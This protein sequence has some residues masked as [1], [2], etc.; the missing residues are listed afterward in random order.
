MMN[1]T[2]TVTLT[3]VLAATALMMT[4]CSTGAGSSTPDARGTTDTSAASAEGSAQAGES[5]QEVAA[6]TPRIFVTYDGGVLALD[7]NTGE[8]QGAVETP[9]FLRLNHAGDGRH[10]MVTGG[11]QFRVLDSGLIT[12]EHGDHDHYYQQDPA[13]TGAAFEASEAGHVVSHHGRTALFADGTGQVQ[14]VE[15]SAFGENAESVANDAES[16][17]YLTEYTTQDSHHGVAIPISDGGLLVTQGTEQSRHT[18]QALDAQG[19]VT[20]QTTDCPGVHGEAVVTGADHGGQ[21]GDVVSFG[22]ENGPVVFRDGQFHKVAVPQSYQRSGNQFAAPGSPVVLTDYKVDADA[23]LERPTRVG[24]LD[25]R[26]D[27]MTTVDLGSPYWFRSLARGAEGQGVVLT[28]DGQ[29]NIIDPQTGEIT[30]RVEVT[31]PWEEN[32]NWQQPGPAVQ[33]SGAY[34]YVT[35]PARQKLHVVNVQ[36]GTVVDTFDL[37][38]T[39]N[40]LAVV[41]GV[42]KSD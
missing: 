23:E 14:V 8:V 29:L 4:A 12:R 20:A 33:V 1:R 28:Y 9:G 10:L 24:L 37:P 39:P 27:Q 34:A 35:E 41:N 36:T 17:N 31:E 42:K 26:S 11:D 5:R 13:W 40:E 19:N 32:E 15:T 7:G 3:S 2:R 6:L 18:I 30:E 38:E 16:K 25:T 21:G 22:C